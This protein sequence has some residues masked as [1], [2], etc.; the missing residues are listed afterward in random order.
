MAAIK[1]KSPT[2]IGGLSEQPAHIRF[3]DQVE[4]AENVLFDVATG[5]AKRP[6]TELLAVVSSLVLSGDYQIYAFDRGDDVDYILLI[7]KDGTGTTVLR[8]FQTD[9]Q[10]ATVNITAN[11]QTYLDASGPLGRD[12]RFANN[13]DLVIILN[14][15]A[16]AAAVS[17]T[18]TPT[19]L[20]IKIVRSTAPTNTAVAVFDA[21][22]NTWTARAS[23]NDTNNP[24]FSVIVE[25]DGLFSDV[26]FYRNRLVLSGEEW[27][28][29]SQAGNYFNFYIQSVASIVDDD[30]LEG[31][32]S[33]EIE[34]VTTFKKALVAFA[35]DGDQYETN[36]ADLLTP[37]TLVFDKTTR[38]ETQNIKP[39]PLG[40]ALYFVGDRNDGAILY[41]YQYDDQQIS[42][43]AANTSRHVEKLLPN[44][45][46]SLTGSAES[47]TVLLIPNNQP[48]DGDFLLQSGDKLLLETGDNLL[49]D[50]EA[51][52]SNEMFV[53]RYYWD[54]DQKRQSAWSK[55]IFGENDRI[56]D[57]AVIGNHCY[58]LTR[59]N[60]SFNDSTGYILERFPLGNDREPDA[61]MPYTVHMDRWQLLAGEFGD[62]ETGW[63]AASNALTIDTVVL[64]PGFAGDAG[65]VLAA[66]QAQTDITVT[67]NYDTDRAYVGQ[68]FTYNLTATEMYRRDRN[69]QADV[70][71]QLNLRKIGIHHFETADYSLVVSDPRRADRN[72]AFSS[73]TPQNGML[74]A[75]FGGQSED[76]TITVQSTSPKPT[77]VSAIEVEANYFGRA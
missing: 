6:G 63:T 21:D 74:E 3:P 60:N 24:G 69:G 45:V 17:G 36:P 38:Y 11:A 37:T 10:E 54:G 22:V 50:R 29:F 48:E 31:R 76:T 5:A 47:T 20:P 27:V 65:T 12:F 2:L 18:P 34:S 15:R 73:D 16:T 75:Y 44:D 1:I 28:D 23:G 77:T 32:L 13:P 49:V 70:M 71:G 25:G 51:I 59:V 7:G 64:G 43:V 56:A 72:K 8:V 40:S 67:G 14:R 33:S 26:A 61:G 55:F 9:G 58:M 46:R 35:A 41:E 42:S 39:V 30:S 4:V 68:C 19:T 66:S 52:G 62:P 53:Y 57:I